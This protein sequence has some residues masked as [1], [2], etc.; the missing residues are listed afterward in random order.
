MLC[1]HGQSPMDSSSCTVCT[2]HCHW[3]DGKRGSGFPGKAMGSVP[4]NCVFSGRS[5]QASMAGSPQGMMRP[6]QGDKVRQHQ[7]QTHPHTPHHT[8]TPTELVTEGQQLRNL[9]AG[10]CPEAPSWLIT[11]EAGRVSVPNPD[12]SVL[13]PPTIPSVPISK[14]P[15]FLHV[16]SLQKKA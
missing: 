4:Q 3:R 8:H 14:E 9:P 16:L 12:S 13:G 15:N 1:F 6:N 11:K 2:G 10:S 7:G 5:L